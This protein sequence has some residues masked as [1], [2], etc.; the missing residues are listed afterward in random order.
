MPISCC[1][2]KQNILIETATCQ[3]CS[4]NQYN[5]PRSQHHY[6]FLAQMFYFMDTIG[7][8]PL[9]LY[10]I[11][12]LFFISTSHFSSLYSFSE[13]LMRALLGLASVILYFLRSSCMYLAWLIAIPSL[14]YLIWSPR[15]KFSSP[16]ML[17][18]NSPCISLGKSLH[19]LMPVAPN[20]L[21]ST[22]TC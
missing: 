12:M 21:S 14:V 2:K 17:I 10:D 7:V 6:I 18:S 16:I 15:K 4:S 8:A 5:F 11:S 3:M 22:Y 20:I 19:K 13:L 9:S 1:T